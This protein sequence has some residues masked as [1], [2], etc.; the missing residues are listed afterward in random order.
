MRALAL[1]FVG[2]AVSMASAQVEVP[3][4]DASV[5][6]EL[7]A[8]Q[9]PVRPGDDFELA[10]IADI[11]PGYHLYGPEEMEPSR[12]ELELTGEPFAFGAP[13]YPAGVTRDLS[14]L[15]TYNLYEGKTVIRVPAQ[16]AESDGAESLQANVI[17]RYQVCT[18]FACSA[19]AVEEL[20]ITLAAA[21]ANAEVEALH[22]EVFDPNP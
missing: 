10:V 22:P 19:P 20:S 14:G 7:V 3:D 17:V 9:A 8:S 16:L 15:G 11:E 18:D 5:R 21:D 12:T 13:A 6:F 4:W 2:A 1:L